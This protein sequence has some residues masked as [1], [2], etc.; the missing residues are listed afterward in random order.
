MGGKKC[1]LGIAV[2]AV[3]VLAGCGS[4]RVQSGTSTGHEAKPP[5]TAVV[6]LYFIRNENDQSYLEKELREVPAEEDQALQVVEE[7]IK[8]P[9]KA[10]GLKPVLPP[11][12]RVLGLQVQDGTCTLNLS[13]EAITG[14]AAIGPC[15]STEKLV[16]GALANTLT[17]IAG[18]TQ[19][20]LLIEGSQDGP[21]SNGML[22]ENFW[23]HIKLPALL[24]RDE[25][26]IGRKQKQPPFWSTV[27][28]RA[29][30]QAWGWGEISR[31]NR[32]KPCIAFTFD[33]GAG[34]SMAS[35]ILDTLKD[36]GVN[37]TFFLTGQFM[38]SYPETVKRILEEGHEVA[39]HSYSHPDF[40]KTGADL[41]EQISRTEREFSVFS[42]LTLKPY[43]RFP[44]GSRNRALIEQLKEIG[45]LGVFWTLDTGGWSDGVSSSTVYSRVM[46]SAAPGAIILMHLDSAPDAQALPELLRDLGA[47]GYRMTSLTEALYPGPQ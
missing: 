29:L 28:R 15:A 9:A 22:I 7:L 31:G 3:M 10:G 40:L 14:A 8:G 41:G 36:Y 30:A 17:E 21:L 47:R 33:G 26:L 11:D 37:P 23:G 6:E 42:S 43:F 19:V 4:S 38:H 16:L 46:N 35:Y 44:Y 25:N 12:T 20:R 13:G 39:S 32:S 34:N 18:I 45:Y 5:D 27:D 24:M 1:I 2:C